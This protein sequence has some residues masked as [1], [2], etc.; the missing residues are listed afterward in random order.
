MCV[1][2][3]SPVIVLETQVNTTGT[4]S[5]GLY[6]QTVKLHYFDVLFLEGNRKRCSIFLVFLCTEYFFDLSI[7]FAFQ[8]GGFDCL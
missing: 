8:S 4:N 2:D 5:N 7:W 3:G 6:I 1:L